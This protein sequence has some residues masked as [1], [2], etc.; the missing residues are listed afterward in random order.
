MRLRPETVGQE[1]R[2]SR[3]YDDPRRGTGT[4]QAERAGV[5]VPYFLE[6]GHN[7]ADHAE[8]EGFH[9]P[10]P[11]KQPDK[12]QE[13][14]VERHTFHPGN[15]IRFLLQ[16]RRLHT[17]SFPKTC[18]DWQVGKYTPFDAR[19]LKIVLFISIGVPCVFLCALNKNNHILNMVRI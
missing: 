10:A 14:L 2:R 6:D 19:A 11:R 15:Q 4:E 8:I 5:E 3:T 16:V 9:D 1:A 12:C 13:G 17:V 7:L 18:A